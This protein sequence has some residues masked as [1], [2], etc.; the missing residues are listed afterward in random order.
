[1]RSSQKFLIEKTA[2]SIRQNILCSAEYGIPDIFE[3]AKNLGFMIIRYPLG[4][5]DILGAALCRGDDKIIFCNSSSILSR[6]IFTVAH[7]IGHHA[8]HLGGDCHEIRDSDFND[9]DAREMEANYFAACL[10]MPEEKIHSFIRMELESKSAE[11][12]EPLEI[13]RIQ[14]AFHVSFDSVLARLNALNILP[15]TVVDK[16]K[17]EKSL[18]SV[19]AL[20]RIIGN[21]AELCSQS[22]VK[23]A[24][25]DFL[26]WVLY[27]YENKLIPKETLERALRYFDIPI[28]EITDETTE[29]S[30]KED[31][32]DNLIGRN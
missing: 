12:W 26:K 29:S 5:Y 7:E 6:E 4:I 14:A 17:S 2:N 32:L 27:N 13:A 31:D 21:G 1:M 11:Q 23:K 25:A 28:S 19:T 18:V 8:L 15:Q 30:A 10:L 24:P 22:N 9:R 16:L 3:S 20:L